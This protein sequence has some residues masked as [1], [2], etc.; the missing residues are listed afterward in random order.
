MV[1]FIYVISSNELLVKTVSEFLMDLDCLL[2]NV[3]ISC[4]YV[5]QKS[6]NIC[7][8]CKYYYFSLRKHWPTSSS[9]SN[10]K[11]TLSVINIGAALQSGLCFTVLLLLK[12][13]LLECNNVFLR[14]ARLSRREH[15]Y[16]VDWPVYRTILYEKNLFS[17]RTV[18]MWNSLRVD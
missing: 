5:F 11:L 1:V 9:R 6:T 16:E 2:Q 18:R 17:R 4:L 14:N 7:V 13:L 15:P 12:S 10:F 3:S 8:F